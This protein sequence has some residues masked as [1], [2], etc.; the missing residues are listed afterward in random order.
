MKTLKPGVRV[1]FI[2]QKHIPKNIILLALYGRTGVIQGASTDPRHDWHVEMDIGAYDIEAKSEALEPIDDADADCLTDDLI[3][4][5]AP[6]N[7][8]ER[9]E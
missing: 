5:E 9:C 2:G 3:P 7:E 6:A 1:R 4:V 8:V